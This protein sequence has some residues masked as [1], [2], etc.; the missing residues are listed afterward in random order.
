MLANTFDVD[1]GDITE[2]IDASGDGAGNPLSGPLSVAVDG[3][4]SVYVAGRFSDNAFQITPPGTITEIIDAAG[5]GAG[6][7]G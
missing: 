2:I 1:E 6:N 3:A 5:D 4:G 7:T